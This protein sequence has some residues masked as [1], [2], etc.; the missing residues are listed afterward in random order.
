M[1]ARRIE[2]LHEFETLYRENFS[3]LYWFSLTLVGERETAC[4][5]VSEVFSQV[6]DRYDLLEHRNMKAY[7]MTS[8]R[9]RCIDHLRKQQRKGE[10]S[11]VYHLVAEVDN[12]MWDEERETTLQQLETA[13]LQLPELTQEVLQLCYYK[14]LTYKQTGDALGMTQRTVKRHVSNDL[15]KLREIMGARKRK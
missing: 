6:W 12:M 4:D 7:L 15:A 1:T 11:D 3:R 9:S 5:I 2:Y 13:I 14:H 10:T 8:V